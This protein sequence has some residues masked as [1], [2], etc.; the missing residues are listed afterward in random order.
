MRSRWFDS[1]PR[2]GDWKVISDLT[3]FTIRASQ[4]AERWDGMIGERNKVEE[5]HP[6]DFL[7]GVKEDQRVPFSRPEQTDRFLERNRT[8]DEL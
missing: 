7:R 3:G 5:R 2:L 8:G 6:M 1:T 4:A